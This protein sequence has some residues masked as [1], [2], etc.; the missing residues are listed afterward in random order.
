MNV[1][2]KMDDIGRVVIPRDLRRSFGWMGGDEIEIIP[3]ADGS[4]L[5]R[6]YNNDSTQ[7]LEELRQEWLDDEDVQQKFLELMNLIKTK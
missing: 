2:K 6:K 7:K 4:I 1:I 3:N 5:L